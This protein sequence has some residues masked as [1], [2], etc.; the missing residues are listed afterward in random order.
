MSTLKNLT[1][2]PDYISKNIVQFDLYIPQMN[3]KRNVYVRLHHENTGALTNLP[4]CG[5]QAVTT[6]AFFQ[7]I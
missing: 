1:K 3:P 6:S 2:V 7:Q 4:V 5:S